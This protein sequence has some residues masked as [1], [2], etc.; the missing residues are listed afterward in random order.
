[1][2]VTTRDRLREG[3]TVPRFEATT[4]DG[5]IVRYADLWQR[6]PVL[7]VCVGDLAAPAARA[8]AAE[9]ETG[10]GELTAHDTACVVT[11]GRVD[12]VPCPGV[13]VA[14]RWGEV[15]FVASAASAAD[16]PRVPALVEWLRFIQSECPECQGEAR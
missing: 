2:K 9:L 6:K 1:M 10:R 12:R 14:D 5:A 15:R 3:D 8:Y 7:L 16:L 13:V 11:A 4:L